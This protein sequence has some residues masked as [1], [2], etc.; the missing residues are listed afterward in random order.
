MRIPVFVLLAALFAGPAPAVAAPARPVLVELFTSQGC[1]SCPPADVVLTRLAADR[2][3]VAV[4]RPVT[5]WDG[6]GWKDSFA[7][8]ENT[9]RQR[10][11]AARFA[12][13][14]VYTPQAVVG[15][16]AQ[17][18]GANE[19][20]LRRLV[21][22]QRPDADVRIAR[23]ADAFTVTLSGRAGAP[24]EVRLI[25]LRRSGVADVK[26]GENGGRT[27]HYTNVVTAERVL[28]RWSGGAMTLTVPRADPA[29]RGADGIA[30]VLQPAALGPVR[31]A[32]V[33]TM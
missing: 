6:L 9:A 29:L 1:S 32:A 24:S 18:L 19:A 23:A 28:A 33:T 3:V 26:R 25:G 15:G 14:S 16:T 7:R 8:P 20:L 13:D 12:S 30:V 11:Y 4:S 31:G 22:A 17:G 5:Y 21:K 10:A 2:G 27:L